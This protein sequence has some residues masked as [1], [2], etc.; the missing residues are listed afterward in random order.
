[1]KSASLNGMRLL[2]TLNALMVTS[3]YSGV[4]AVQILP[5][6]SRQWCGYEARGEHGYGQ[7]RLPSCRNSNATSTVESSFVLQL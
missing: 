3:S 4:F 1:M 2:C 6:R 7:V 5:R